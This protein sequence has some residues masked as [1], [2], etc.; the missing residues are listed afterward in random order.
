MVAFL[1]RSN[2]QQKDSLSANIEAQ[3]LVTHQAFSLLVGA[4]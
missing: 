4:R 2:V 1:Q 3:L